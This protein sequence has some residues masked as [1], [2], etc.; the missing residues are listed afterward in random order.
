MREFLFLFYQINLLI[1]KGLIG[2]IILIFGPMVLF[3]SL[4]PI[5][6]T[7]PVTGSKVTLSIVIN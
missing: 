1:K 6:E 3:S 2:L 7:N 5:T 4:N